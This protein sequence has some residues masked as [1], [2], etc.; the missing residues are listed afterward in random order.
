MSEYEN[1]TQIIKDEKQWT[2]S[3]FHRSV[4]VAGI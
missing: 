1:R 2:P 3:P 4:F